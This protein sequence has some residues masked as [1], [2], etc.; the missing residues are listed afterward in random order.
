MLLVARDERAPARGPAK[1]PSA[2]AGRRA[3]A[4]RCSLSTS[5]TTTPASACW[6]RANEY[7]GA[8]DV[9][10]NNAG[11]AQWRDLDDVPDEDWRD[12]VRAQ[13]DGAAAGDARRRPGDG[14]AWLGPRRQ[15]LL[16]RRQAT[17]GG[18]A[19]VLGRQ[20]RRALAL[21]PL[22]RPLRQV[23]RP[24]QRRSVPARPNRRCGWRP[25][26]CSTSRRRWPATPAARRRWRAP[27]P[28][29][30]S[31]AS[32]RPTEIAAAIVFLCSER[33]SYV[34]GA[35]WSRRRRHGPGDHLTCVRRLST[36]G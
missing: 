33:A 6:P 29:A 11:V 32:P 21:A 13:R 16:D 30:R 17:L 2:P 24:R 5:P 7:F 36:C 10:V 26:A 18:D 8:L 19:R 3:A 25:A 4:P 20:G 14:R 31:A 23:R 1:R 9:L 35:A 12:A 28:S 22:R 27:A 15:R 34:A